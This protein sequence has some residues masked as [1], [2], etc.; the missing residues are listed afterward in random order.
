MKRW[1][2]IT[3]VLYVVAL[4]VVTLP[5]LFPLT[6]ESERDLVFGFYKYFAPPLVLIL[7]VFLLLPV[8]AAQGRPV[9]RRKAIT[10]AV[11]IAIPM[12]ALTILG[13]FSV[14]D[15]VWG[16]EIGLASSLPDWS[17]L[18]AMGIAWL[19][20]AITFFRMYSRA[21]ADDPT[22]T[23]SAWLLRGSILETV[24]AVPAHI[25]SRR[26]DECC[27]PGLTLLGIATGLAVALMS[28]GPG[29][30]FLFAK[31]VKEKRRAAT[32]GSTSP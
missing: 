2:L 12:M 4:V 14:L 6:T 25:V 5:V 10:S 13:A 26:R 21:G 8:D 23:V 19:A 29:V 16:E 18:V 22:A 30:F 7:G 17:W 32:K 3:V 27:A 28:F 20:W 24:I 9:K 1:A 11:V 15:L 31:R